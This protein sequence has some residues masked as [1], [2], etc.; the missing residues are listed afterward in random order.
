VPLHR[1]CS[2]CRSQHACVQ[3]GLNSFG[4]VCRPVTKRAN[5]HVR[6][7]HEGTSGGERSHAARAQCSMKPAFAA[8]ARYSCFVP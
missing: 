6:V 5:L 8:G 4:G 7:L 3:G 2:Q 1:Q